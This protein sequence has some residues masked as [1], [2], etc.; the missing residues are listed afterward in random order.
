MLWFKQ[1][2]KYGKKCADPSSGAEV[3]F[4]MPGFAAEGFNVLTADDLLAIPENVSLLKQIN[5]AVGGSETLYTTYLLP[6]I[7]RCA[8]TV[9]LLAASAPDS[10]TSHHSYAGGLLRHLLETALFCINEGRS[11]YINN[12]V[13]PSCREQNREIFILCCALTGL[14]HDLGKIFDQE[15]ITRTVTGE[16]VCWDPFEPLPEFL[17]R[18]HNI[19]YEHVFD[20]D[21]PRY[22]VKK[23]R[24][25]RGGEHAVFS[26]F[27]Q[28][29]FTLKNFLSHAFT[30]N[31]DILRE[32]MG[33]CVWSELDKKFYP[34]DGNRLSRCLFYADAS[35]CEWDGQV[36]RRTAPEI[37]IRSPEVYAAVGKMLQQFISDGTLLINKTRG[38]ALLFSSGF[39]RS[40]PE[41]TGLDCD[42]FKLYLRFDRTLEFLLLSKIRQ[43]LLSDLR[44]DIFHGED[45]TLN[46]LR[47]FLTTIGIIEPCRYII[48]PGALLFL[49]H[50]DPFFTAHP[51]L[52]PNDLSTCEAAAFTNRSDL[53]NAESEIAADD[54][55]FKGLLRHRCTVKKCI[56]AADSQTEGKK[57]DDY[58]YVSEGILPDTSIPAE[59]L[60]EP[61]K[62]ANNA[63][64][65]YLTPQISPKNELPSVPHPASTSLPDRAAS[66][67]S[68]PAINAAPDPAVNNG[69]STKSPLRENSESALIHSMLDK[70]HGENHAAAVSDTSTALCEAEEYR[71]QSDMLQRTG[72]KL[73]EESVRLDRLKALSDLIAAYK[74]H[75]G[76]A[77]VSLPELPC[78]I[79]LPDLVNLNARGRGELIAQYF[80][81]TLPDKV[82][83]TLNRLIFPALDAHPQSPLELRTYDGVNCVATIRYDGKTQKKALK[84]TIKLLRDNNLLANSDDPTHFEHEINFFRSVQLIRPFAFILLCGGVPVRSGEYLAEPFSRPPNKPTTKDIF[85]FFKYRLLMLEPGDQLYGSTVHAADTDATIRT[86]SIAAVKNCAREC[87]VQLRGFNTLL[88]PNGQKTPPVMIQ[89]GQT[90]IVYPYVPAHFHGECD[91]V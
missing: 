91:E 90:L 56:P 68:T 84:K 73:L 88:L 43:H 41:A 51:D 16:E 58:K 31:S 35:S 70:I 40:D 24:R 57:D 65:F 81:A 38:D 48:T 3:R 49:K 12:D 7:R 1:K 4:V 11:V 42:D 13:L 5:L 50:D 22:D 77:A 27:L 18:V 6:A 9:Q 66:A 46:A 10:P 69:A 44:I 21:G 62:A 75:G 59:D 2:N 39:N 55:C 37:N 82:K 79:A 23:W 87:G 71:E 20:A 61:P 80:L 45:P 64:E 89:K 52:L 60:K 83:G 8:Y 36:N 67:S 86:V 53:I 19:P 85:L 47:D 72:L 28:R 74:T 14:T 33:A 78:S 30:V 63:S 15:V 26:T 54:S 17:C 29:S 25:D 76:E 32:F 34:S